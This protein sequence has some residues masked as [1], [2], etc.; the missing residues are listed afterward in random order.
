M[1]VMLKTILLA[2]LA[3]LVLTQIEAKADFYKYTDENG[4]TIFTDDLS[5]IPENQR[6]KIKKYQEPL[7]LP[8]TEKSVIK[9]PQKST[10]ENSKKVSA[11]IEE[12]NA[13]KEELEKRQIHLEQEYETLMKEKAALEHQQA[14][15]KGR[16]KIKVYNEQVRVFSDKLNKYNKKR[17]TL[18]AEVSEY[19]KIIE[20]LNKSSK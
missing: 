11:T 13:K 17:I 7:S 1:Q 9:K 4:S 6:N 3:M 15:A 2:I 16:N 20:K 12:I 18:E 14:E 5:K 8:K 10:P 19:N